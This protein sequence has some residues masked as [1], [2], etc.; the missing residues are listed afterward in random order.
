VRFRDE[1]GQWRRSKARPADEV[2]QRV[3]SRASVCARWQYHDTE[4][5]RPAVAD[6]AILGNLDRRAPH[7]FVESRQPTW[8]RRELGR[9]GESWDG[10]GEQEQGP[11]TEEAAE[12]LRCPTA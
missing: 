12:Q 9:R 5:N 7:L 6:L 10:E 4:S 8:P 2:E 3:T 11:R 1:I